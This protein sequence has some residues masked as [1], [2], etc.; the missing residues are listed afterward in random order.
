MCI[1][2]FTWKQSSA[3]FKGMKIL[4][5]YILSEYIKP[6]VYC[7][8][9][10]SMI[11]VLWDLMGHLSKFI[12]AQASPLLIAKYYIFVLAPALVLLAPASLLL[13][14]LYTLWQFSRSNQLIAMKASG[15]GLFRIMY[16]FLW[17]GVIS[18]LTIALIN[19]FAVTK[20]TP[21]ADEF[22]KN[23]YQV[24]ESNIIENHAFYSPAT[25][26]QWMI[27]SFD[28]KHPN[29]LNGV[30]ISQEHN[31]KTL[32]WTLAA[33]SAHWLDGQWWLF[34][35]STRDYTEQGRPLGKKEVFI[36][37][38]E[39]G[40]PYPELIETPAEIV[41]D[42]R[43]WEY[44]STL[45][46]KKFLHLNKS[47]STRAKKEKRFDLHNRIAMPW[48]CL[49]VTMFGIPMGARTARQGMLTGILLAISL[50]LGFY[51]FSQ[52]GLFLAKSEKEFIA[53]WLGAWLS[54][55]VFMAI[56]VVMSIRMR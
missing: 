16:P 12:G 26:R 40:K 46:M 52:V 36:E 30:T 7:L 31:N 43:K 49:V 15:I 19:E 41:R 28:S 45:E 23:K 38:S 13:A 32:D 10:F 55:L 47:I 50:L 8:L 24:V 3:T 44:F 17:I 42:T 33:A 22:T 54:N 1:A 25:M 11:F 14:T 56:G 53:P 21:W 51:F 5:K 34:N 4:D 9:A 18:S 29:I 2:H 35:A 6:V 20:M 39:L 48:A 37:G 27:L